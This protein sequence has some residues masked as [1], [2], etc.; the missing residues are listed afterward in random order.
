MNIK[1]LSLVA[2]LPLLASCS[3]AN[4]RGYIK[5]QAGV[6]AYNGDTP[7]TSPYEIDGHVKFKVQSTKPILTIEVLDPATVI[8]T[9]VAETRGRLE[10]SGVTD[11]GNTLIIRK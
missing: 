7:V 1:L 11:G 9:Q 3:S 6:Q 5:G 4:A 2:L 10:G 8:R